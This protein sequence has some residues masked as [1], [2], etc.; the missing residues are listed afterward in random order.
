MAYRVDG[1]DM[2][3]LFIHYI[4]EPFPHQYMKI[5]LQLLSEYDLSK[6]F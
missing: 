6:G 5:V 3:H 2:T 4:L 1:L